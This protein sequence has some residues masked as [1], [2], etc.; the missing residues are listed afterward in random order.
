MKLFAFVVAL[1]HVEQTV[2]VLHLEAL[3]I[4]IYRSSN[5]FDGRLSDASCRQRQ[6]EDILRMLQSWLASLYLRYSAGTVNMVTTR[7]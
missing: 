3:T 7:G 4:G 6:M 1:A 5:T 2:A